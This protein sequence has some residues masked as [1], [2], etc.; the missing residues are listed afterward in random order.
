MLLCTIRTKWLY[1]TV[2]PE[3]F[4]LVLFFCL[5]DTRSRNS[6]IEMKVIRFLISMSSSY[7][8]PLLSNREQYLIGIIKNKM[9]DYFSL[10][11][12][13]AFSW[14]MQCQNQL[15]MAFLVFWGYTCLCKCLMCQNIWF[16]PSHFTSFK[17]SLNTVKNH[18]N[19]R[20]ISCYLFNFTRICL[21]LLFDL[22]INYVHT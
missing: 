3:F 8:V 13:F 7:I 17:L 14:G 22:V 15:Q 18:S 11:C 10:L 16:F 1:L 21:H 12:I 5:H 6:Q 20:L 9:S 19:L 2:S 4:K